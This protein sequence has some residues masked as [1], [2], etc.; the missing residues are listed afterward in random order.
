MYCFLLF[1]FMSGIIFAIDPLY[2]YSTFAGADLGYHNS[3]SYNR[4]S[5]SE[6]RYFNFE[7]S[8]KL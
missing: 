8:L 2:F 1:G 7:R 4:G 5:L 6:L 3:L